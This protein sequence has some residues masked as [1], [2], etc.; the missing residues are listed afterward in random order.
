VI[1]KRDLLFFGLLLAGA[2]ALA[3]HLVPPRRA[4][5]PVSYDPSPYHASDFRTGVTKLNE[6]VNGTIRAESLKVAQPA[7]DLTIARRLA[8]ALAGTVPSLEE[9]RRFEQLPPGERLP[10]YLDTLL[11]DPRHADYF[12]ERWARLT[13]G[14]EDGP[15]VL[16]RRR[17]YVAWLSDQFQKNRPY[18]ALVRELLTAD[19]LWTDHPA[20]NFVTVTLQQ[21]DGKNNQ[22]DPVRLA[23]RTTRAFLGLRIDCAQCHDHPFAS[24]KQT[25]FEGLSAFFGQTHVGFSGLYDGDGDYVIEEPG[26][27][28]KTTIEPG[29]PFSPEFLPAGGTRRSRLAAWVTHPQNPY[30]AK[31]LVNRVWAL[32]F[33]RPIVAPV[34][35]IES[36]D[37]PPA[38][39]TLLADDFVKH[40][41]DL[42]RLIRTIAASEAF[43]RRSSVDF[44]VTKLHEQTGAVFPLTRMRPEQTAGAVL[45]AAS[46]TTQNSRSHIVLRLIRFGR[47]NDFLQRYADNAEDELDVRVGTIPQRLLMMNGKMVT[48]VVKAEPLN[49]SSRIS[50][51]TPTDKA[52]I[53]AAFLAVLTRRPSET[54]LNFFRERLDDKSQPRSQHLEDL[55][56]ALL[57]STEFSWQ[58]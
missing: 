9:I 23:G 12:A 43:A 4:P 13:V 10:W 41:Y 26:T 15:F 30:F 55:F 52:A 25:D 6:A 57:N 49:A 20:T 50:V 31:A 5:G 58:H 54:E 16:F 34:D 21:G 44:E 27:G 17:R 36:G 42:R 33:G 24:W 28:E 8:S 14:T 18:D 11:D 45:Q 56:W 29:V 7:D 46:I 38:I 32:M 2:G 53:D 22:P 40:G 51:L 1:G 35:N 19:G 39:L 3:F 47:E 37:A 48:D